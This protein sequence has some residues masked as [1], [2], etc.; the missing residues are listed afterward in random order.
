ML[1]LILVGDHEDQIGV[2]RKIELAHAEP[3]ECDH[4]EPAA[5][6]VRDINWWM[7]LCN[8]FDSHAIRCANRGVGKIGSSVQCVENGDSQADARGL[9]TEHLA[10]EPT[11]Q[12][13]SVRNGA[14]DCE[15][16]RLDDAAQ[17]IDQVRIAD[18]LIGK[19]WSVLEHIERIARQRA[20]IVQ[21]RQ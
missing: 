21:D 12:L 18:R 15:L 16:R 13:R 8:L 10:P 4:H 14:R 9:Q 6:L 17:L 7:H 11:A 20:V 5:R 19:V 1:G 2:R 3:S